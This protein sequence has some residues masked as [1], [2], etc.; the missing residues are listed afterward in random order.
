MI[1][2]FSR[3]YRTDDDLFLCDMQSS[4]CYVI[5]DINETQP[6]LPK[7]KLI[8]PNMTRAFIDSAKMVGNKKRVWGRLDGS[9]L[10]K[11]FAAVAI[12]G[13]LIYGFMIGGGGLHF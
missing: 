4:D 12:V 13:S 11:Y 2:I 6:Y 10:Y 8:D 5:Y 7:A 1:S 3:L 9:Q